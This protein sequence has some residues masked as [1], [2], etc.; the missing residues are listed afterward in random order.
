MANESDARPDT[1]ITTRTLHRERVKV[2]QSVAAA[3]GQELRQPVYA[4]TSA[5]QLLRYRNIEDPLIERN[6]GR[7][8][9][10]TERLNTLIAA[11]VDYGQPALVQLAPGHPDEVWTTV[12]GAHRGML[13]SKAIL[14]HHA[15]PRDP[16][17]F[18]IDA[19]QLAHAFGNLIVNAVDAAP[20]GTDLTIHSS[21]DRDGTWRSIVHNDGPAIA[22]DTLPRVFEPLVTTKPGRVGMG[23]A[24]AHR[25][26]SEH[27]GTIAIDSSESTGTTVTITLP[28]PSTRLP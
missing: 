5:A 23:L 4:I 9:R 22:P 18:A 26:L 14:A 20:E 11:L 27:G 16:A 7:I 2:S 15:A 24:V 12:L 10:E 3:I 25:I 28:N 1:P 6:L 19:D 13:E 21:V 17:A 8:M